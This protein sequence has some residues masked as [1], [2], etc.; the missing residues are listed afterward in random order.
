MRPKLSLIA[1]RQKYEASGQMKQ[2]IVCIV[3]LASSLSAKVI[4]IHP[5]GPS[6]EAFEHDAQ[7]ELDSRRDRDIIDDDH[8]SQDEKSEAYI[9]CHERGEFV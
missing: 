2:L 9:R 1:P 5:R 6:E 3:I 4:D 7:R 8:S